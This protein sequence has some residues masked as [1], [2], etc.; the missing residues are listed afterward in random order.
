MGMRIRFI[1]ISRK[2][3][4]KLRS[5]LVKDVFVDVYF[6]DV[7]IDPIPEFESQSQNQSRNLGEY[8]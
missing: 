6:V 1:I 4:S 7:V 3:E 2:T 5:A 8:K